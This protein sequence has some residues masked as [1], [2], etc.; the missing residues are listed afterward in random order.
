MSAYKG[1]IV[2]KS[3]PISG[4]RTIK[5]PHRLLS[6]YTDAAYHANRRGHKR[7]A[8]YL[9]AHSPDGQEVELHVEKEEV[10]DAST[11]FRLPNPLRR[12]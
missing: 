5:P 4:Q 1:E 2:T 12:F 9:D 3:H 7:P 11:W 6:P 8:S 10:D